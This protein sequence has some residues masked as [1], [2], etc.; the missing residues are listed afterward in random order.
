[1][2]LPPDTFFIS[3]LSINTAIKH[4]YHQPSPGSAR[5]SRVSNIRFR[6]FLANQLKQAAVPFA[7]VTKHTFSRYL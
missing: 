7:L 5:C 4:A 2:K 1:M 6:S 3:L